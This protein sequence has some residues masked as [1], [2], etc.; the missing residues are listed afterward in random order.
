MKKA[1]AVLVSLVA[2]AA[3]AAASLYPHKVLKTE[4]TPGMS[5]KIAF[6]V[7]VDVVKGRLPSKVEMGAISNVL[8]ASQKDRSDVYV[9]FM[10]P[11]MPIGEGAFATAHHRAT[12]EP[13]RVMSF[14][15]P[16]KY[17]KLAAAVEDQ[18]AT[19]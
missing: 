16:A 10:L 3:V 5:H 7:L 2:A 19:R 12:P 6:Y 4:T 13:V 18:G 8:R 1:T 14:A 17:M 15:V 9:F 11:G